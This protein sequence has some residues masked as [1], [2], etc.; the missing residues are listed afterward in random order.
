M[1]LVTHMT[2]AMCSLKERKKAMKIKV[3]EN[4]A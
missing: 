3:Y 1:A 2:A 4:L